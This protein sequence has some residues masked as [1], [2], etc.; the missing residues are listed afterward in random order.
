M[1][2]CMYVCTYVRTYVCM[3]VCM[4]ACMHACM[5]ACMYVCMYVCVYIY[6]Y[7]CTCNIVYILCKLLTCIRGE[8]GAHQRR[9]AA[10]PLQQVARG[11]AGDASRR[12]R[13]HAADSR[14]QLRRRR[15]A[16]GAP[17]R[18]GE[19]A[20]RPVLGRAPLPKGLGQG[21]F[22][23]ILLY[24]L[25]FHYIHYSYYHSYYCTR[26]GPPGWSSRCWRP[27]WL[28]RRRA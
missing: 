5:H 12:P 10:W 8:A 4:Y 3:Y 28:A 27:G 16:A 24:F 23:S 19:G 15:R 1:Y 17:A 22:Y 6:I 7:I 11:W 25:L 20:G 21:I 13:G 2:V 18:P 14:R 26:R 9:G